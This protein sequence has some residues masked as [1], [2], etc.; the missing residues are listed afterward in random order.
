MHSAGDLGIEIDF[1]HVA[2]V[3]D[4]RLRRGFVFGRG[5]GG[6]IRQP[7]KSARCGLPL[8]LRERIQYWHDIQPDWL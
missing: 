6:S 2:D 7:Q 3:Y 1:G 4:R 5:F 8:D